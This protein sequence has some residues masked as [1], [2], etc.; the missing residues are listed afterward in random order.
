MTMTDTNTDAKSAAKPGAATR[1]VP[2]RVTFL[3]GKRLGHLAV[4]LVVAPANLSDDRIA[5]M[6]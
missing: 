1:H 5:T 4:P 6:T 3:A 2:G